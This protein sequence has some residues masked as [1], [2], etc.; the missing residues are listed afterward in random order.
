MA[1]K[2]NPM[3]TASDKLL[4]TGL[5]IRTEPYGLN[6]K[7]EEFLG[8]GTQGEVYG[9]KLGGDAVALKWYFREW[10][11]AEQ[12]SA[13]EIL[14]R[15]EVPNDRFLWPIAL[16]TSENVS[17]FGYIMP[18]REPR[19]A[20]IVALMTRNV[21]PTF[22][23]LTT[24]GLHLA[25]C[26]LQLHSQ[27]LCYRDISFGNVF[28]EPTAGDI[29]ICDNDNVTV[30]GTAKAGV[31]GT[32]RFM[33]PEVV[34][35]EALP[36]IES[37][38]YSLATLLFY[39]FMLH[40]PLEGKKEREIKCLDPPAMTRLYG[41]DPIFIFDPNDR[42]NAPVAGE[43]DNAIT[44]WPIYP[45]FLRDRFITAFTDGIRNPQNGRV[46]ESQWRGDMVRLRDA[47]I[48]CQA[49]AAENFYDI[50]MMTAANKASP[51]CWRCGKDVQVP[52]RIRIG[53]DI[54]VALNH[55]T[56]LFPHHIDGARMYDFSQPVAAVERHP[57]NPN[58]WGLKNL[59]G[60][61]WV[62]TA[63]GEADRD[64]APGRSVTLAPGIKINFGKSQ[65]EVRL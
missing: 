26:Y 37:D 8:A 52:P 22:R 48:Y 19:F 27:G 59:S 49:C 54:L 1:E 25:H 57:Y 24:A 4:R 56:K 10:A 60:D 12:R 38:L 63:A 28:F 51:P 2:R 55:D 61:R 41:T 64:V 30:N 62:C 16:A 5:T 43:H 3:A 13:L 53:K 7:V 18:L 46:R 14:I 39:M 47:I 21:E 58:I 44:F 9:A 50:Q 23:T 42:S 15:K 6:C 11:T 65:G 29:L 45:Q 32:P 33:A 34:R 17:G 31:L 40:H 35:G 36:N 20:S